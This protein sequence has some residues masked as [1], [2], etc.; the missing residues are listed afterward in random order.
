MNEEMVKLAKELLDA[1]EAYMKAYEL[2]TKDTKPVVWVRHDETK[3]MVIMTRGE[4]SEQ[5][6][7]YIDS[8]MNYVL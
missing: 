3:A 2:E 8:G 4:Y 1:S 6:Q 5:L 7:S